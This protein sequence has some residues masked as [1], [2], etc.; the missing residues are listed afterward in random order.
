[1]AKWWRSMRCSSITGRRTAAKHKSGAEA[2]AGRR[3]SSPPTLELSTGKTNPQVP[4]W[5]KRT[6]VG[7][8]GRTRM[9]LVPAKSS[10]VRWLSAEQR[11]GA[12]RGRLS[13]CTC[14]CMRTCAG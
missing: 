11:G 9:K 5:N 1:M 12:A 2:A 6:R 3:D 4:G 10:V 8:V 14:G 13:C 7:L